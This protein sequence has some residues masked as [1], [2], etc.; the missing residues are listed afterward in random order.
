[1]I[2]NIY[3]IRRAIDIQALVGNAGGYIGLC[4]GYSFLQIPDLIL[5]FCQIVKKFYLKKKFGVTD[6][7]SLA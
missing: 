6:V 5:H 7:E 2:I 3:E 4:V 1:V